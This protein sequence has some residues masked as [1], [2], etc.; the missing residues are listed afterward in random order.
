LDGI[1]FEC[2]NG[3]LATGFCS[4]FKKRMADINIFRETPYFK[5]FP[6]AIPAKVVFKETGLTFKEA[7]SKSRY[8]K[9]MVKR[10][11]I[12]LIKTGRWPIGGAFREYLKTGRASPRYRGQG[13]ILS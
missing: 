5:H 1:Y 2:A 9:N 13:S 10:L 4:N 6:E 3:V 12:N 11:K 8:L 7:Y